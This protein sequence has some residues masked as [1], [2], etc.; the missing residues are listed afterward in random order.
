MQPKQQSEHHEEA[1]D[2]PLERI[3]PDTLRKMI[4]EFAMREWS[5]LSGSEYTLDE[6]I[7]QVLQQLKDKRAKI[8]LIAHPKHGI[9]F[10]V[11][12]KGEKGIYDQSR[13]RR[14][15]SNVHR[16]DE[17]GIDRGAGNGA[18]DHEI[19]LKQGEILKISGFG[20]FV[21]K[22][23]NDRRGRNP[24]TGE[25][26]TINARRILTFKPSGVLKSRITCE[27]LP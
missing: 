18:V 1:I 13:H 2:I 23:K 15:D 21:V 17:E 11:D 4:E 7:D 9:S 3:N 19:T 14:K 16:N 12:N 26:I 5:E 20:N 22:E 6:K 8:A 24:Q 10:P 27:P 25:T